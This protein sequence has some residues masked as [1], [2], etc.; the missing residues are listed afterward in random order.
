MEKIFRS[1]WKTVLLTTL[2]A[3]INDIIL[4]FTMVTIKSGNFP[5]KM[6]LYMAGGALGVE[7]AMS[8]GFW[9]GAVGLLFHFIISFAFTILVFIIFP[10][11]KLQKFNVKWLVLF[12][13]VYTVFMNL[14]MRYVVLPL[15]L[16]PPPQKPFKLSEIWPGWLI[17]TIIFSVPIF[18]AASKYYRNKESY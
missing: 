3:G 8:G 16:L 11:L 18:W 6:L 7:K 17:F 9:T 13:C 2:I 4:A 5:S 1:F 12:S 10:V 14:W 15:T